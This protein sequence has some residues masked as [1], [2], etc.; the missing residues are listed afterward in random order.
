MKLLGNGPYNQQNYTIQS[1]KGNQILFLQ[2]NVEVVPAALKNIEYIDG[3]MHVMFYGPDG[4]IDRMAQKAYGT[5]SL[6]ARPF[7]LR[8]WFS[9]LNYVCNGYDI[10]ETEVLGI[11]QN[12]T[13][14][15]TNQKKMQSL[16]RT[17]QVFSMRQIWVRMLVNR[18]K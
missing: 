6:Y 12:V 2:D 14:S 7:V 9:L 11:V 1:I 17:W 13:T 5:A 15:V 8:K 3:L 4:S 10:D 16:F 18:N